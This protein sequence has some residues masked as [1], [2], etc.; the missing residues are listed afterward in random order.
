MWWLHTYVV[1]S[2]GDQTFTQNWRPD[3]HLQGMGPC[4]CLISSTLLIDTLSTY[5]WNLR[6]ISGGRVWTRQ[7][8]CFSLRWRHWR[9]WLI[10]RVEM[11]DTWWVWHNEPGTSVP[12]HQPNALCWDSRSR[13]HY[14]YCSSCSRGYGYCRSGELVVFSCTEMLYMCHCIVLDVSR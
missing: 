13:F 5:A 8:Y 2:R 9:T 14:R 7:R 12:P 6:C 11:L 3:V 1:D 10:G 4:V